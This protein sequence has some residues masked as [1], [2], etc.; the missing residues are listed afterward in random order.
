[1][2]RRLFNYAGKNV[3]LPT[4]SRFLQRFGY[5]TTYPRGSEAIK[6]ISGKIRVKM[7]EDSR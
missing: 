4:T 7:G 1:M 6:D 2:K 5:S 3:T